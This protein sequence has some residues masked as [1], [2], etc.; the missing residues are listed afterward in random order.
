MA[1]IPAR[2]VKQLRETT[3]AGLMDCQRALEATAEHAGDESKWLAEA[4]DWLREHGVAK[5]A[6]R[7]GRTTNQGV[8]EAYVHSTG[9]APKLGV[10]VELD[11]ETDFV[12]NTDEFKTL[13][14]ELALQ[15]AGG[16]PRYVRREDVPA[17]LVERETGVYRTQIEGKP[18]NVQEKILQGKLE[19]WYA[20][21]CLLDQPW[22]RDE[23]RKKKVAE[24]IKETVAKVQENISVAR[25]ARFEV[26]EAPANGGGAAGE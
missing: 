26:G 12:A 7:A 18:E 23:K 19:A 24:L 15:V 21:I 5:A 6:A 3:S 1:E 8:V 10:L 25:F 4:V 14:R 11:C 22:I 20:E 16:A 13:A 9:G 2:L 17:E